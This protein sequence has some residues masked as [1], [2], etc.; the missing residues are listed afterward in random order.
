MLFDYFSA[1]KR[2]LPEQR[3]QEGA[4]GTV[5]PN[6][7]QVGH[8]LPNLQQV[9]FIYTKLTPSMA[10]LAILGVFPAALGNM[11]MLVRFSRDR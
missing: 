3:C 9:W 10:I 6:L 11:I 5:L 2:V 7:Q 8:D 4:A 1:A